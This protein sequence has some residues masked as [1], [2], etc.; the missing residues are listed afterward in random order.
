[1]QST[2]FEGLC[3]R[4]N[5]FRALRIA[6]CHLGN[7]RARAKRR[8][9]I[10]RRQSPCRDQ[11]GAEVMRTGRSQHDIGGEV[12]I[13]SP[14]NLSNLWLVAIGKSKLSRQVGIDRA[15]GQARVSTCKGV[16]SNSIGCYAEIR[17][18]VQGRAR[19]FE[20]RA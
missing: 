2:L 3:V 15:T 17:G 14:N 20:L 16:S 4:T 11:A 1:M 5:P 6:E 12:R 18:S 8:A 7:T 13:G 19:A 9:A 10:D